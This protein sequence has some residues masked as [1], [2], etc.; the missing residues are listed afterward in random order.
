MFASFPASPQRR[1]IS[2][3]DD[4]GTFRPPRPQ[5]CRGL[6]GLFSA[7]SPKP[8]SSQ[9]GRGS[10]QEQQR[11]IFSE[12]WALHHVVVYLLWVWVWV[13]VLYFRWNFVERS[14]F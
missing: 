3:C 9:L 12:P 7:N 11:G 4:R 5:G 10:R 13:W 6:P 14:L 8:S 1:L 2:R